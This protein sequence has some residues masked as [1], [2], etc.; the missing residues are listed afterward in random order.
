MDCVVRAIV[1]DYVIEHLD[2]TDPRPKFEIYIVWKAKILQNWKYLV[3]TSLNDGMYYEMTFN[4][5]KQEWYLDAYKKFE[6]RVVAFFDGFTER[7][8]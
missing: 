3:S 8:V 1:E 6:N 7:T 5:D 2:K 4:G